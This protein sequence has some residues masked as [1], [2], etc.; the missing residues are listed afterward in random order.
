M[1]CHLQG[2][3]LDTPMNR[4]FIQDCGGVHMSLDFTLRPGSFQPV[5]AVFFLVDRY[6]LERRW[7]H[8]GCIGI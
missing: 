7:V 3:S 4:I 8:L 2:T 5:M 1:L 6:C